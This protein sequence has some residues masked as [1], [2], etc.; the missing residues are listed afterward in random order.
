MSRTA[1]NFYFNSHT[2]EPRPAIAQDSSLQYSVEHGVNST[3]SES[4]TDYMSNIIA[5]I[6]LC[7]NKL[8]ECHST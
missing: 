4:K 2:F 3:T 8:S 1:I 5:S 7:F 6:P